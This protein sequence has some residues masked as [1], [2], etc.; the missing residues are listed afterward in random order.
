MLV[1]NILR[2]LTILQLF[3]LHTLRDRMNREQ[4]V[5][6]A[7]HCAVQEGVFPGAVLHVRRKGQVIFHH[8]VG[9]MEPDNDTPMTADTIFDLA[10]LTKPLATTTAILCLVQDGQLALTHPVGMWVPELTRTPIGEV[11]I[12]WVLGHRAG[13]P[14]WRPYFPELAPHAKAPQSQDEVKARQRAFL[15]RL[16]QEPLVYEPGTQTRYSDLGFMVLGI[17]VERCA[18]S[19]L[20]DYCTARIYRPLH[21]MPLYFMDVTSMTASRE[22]NLTLLAPTEFDPW[23]G[24]KLQGEVHDEHAYALGGIAGHAGLFGTAQ[25]VGAVAQAWLDG[26]LTQHT[27]LPQ[28]LVR[29]FVQR[30]TSTSSWALGWD[31]PSLPS[32]SGSRLSRQAFGHLGFT[33]TSVWIDP[34]CELIVVLLSNRVCPTRANTAIQ[35]FRPRLH[36]LVYEAFVAQQEGKAG[37]NLEEEAGT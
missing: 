4:A 15:Y 7:L 18:M 13:L 26:F 3:T 11:A 16:A 37:D 14:A 23:R 36:D 10:S 19:S 31:T 28:E 12:A 21:A 30:Q 20:A 8:A 29:H 35:A 33:G 25:A 5:V 24:R 17:V 1:P 34:A 22:R 32:S 27:F 2:F 9:R 6:Q